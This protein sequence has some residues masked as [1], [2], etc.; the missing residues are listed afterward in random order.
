MEASEEWKVSDDVRV[1][2][3]LLRA[4]IHEG[5]A[6]TRRVLVR[7]AAAWSVVLIGAVW[8]FD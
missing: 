4:T 3:D 6:R 1:E 5:Y 7:F 2:I 8:L